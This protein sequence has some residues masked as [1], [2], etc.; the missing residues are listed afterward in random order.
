MYQAGTLSGNPVAMAAGLATLEAL[1]E[2]G[3]YGALEARSAQLEQGLTAAAGKAGLAGKVCLQRVGSMLSVF[4]RPPPVASYEDAAGG[5]AKAFAAFFHA[6]LGA[7]VYLAPS[8]F[9]AMFV[10]ARHTEQDVADTA[11]AAEGAFA[12]AAAERRRA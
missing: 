9:E 12:A 11:R 2:D 5:D 1:R 3:F 10:S 8:R 4:F 6:M 7:G